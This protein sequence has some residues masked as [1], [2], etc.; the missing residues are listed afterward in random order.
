MMTKNIRN[1]LT[2]LIYFVF[3]QLYQTYL[4]LK[5]SQLHYIIHWSI[6][7]LTLVLQQ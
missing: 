6:P 1:T 2:L 3:Y 7:G 5:S 4:Y